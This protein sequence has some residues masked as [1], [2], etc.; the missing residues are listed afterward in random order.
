MDLDLDRGEIGDWH[1]F[2]TFKCFNDY[3]QNPLFQHYHYHYHCT[4]LPIIFIDYILL[5]MN[6]FRLNNRNNYR[7][8]IID[9]WFG[10]R[11]LSEI[12]SII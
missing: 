2:I 9:G 5:C 8:W 11:F 3:H 4:I 1:Y 6:R 7:N 10:D 12:K